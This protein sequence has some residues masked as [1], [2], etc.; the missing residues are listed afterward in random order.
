M[1]GQLVP[2]GLPVKRGQWVLRDLPVKPALPVLKVLPVSLAPL[3]PKD[4]LVL[5]D[6]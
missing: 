3:V 4:P 5:P 2:R 1:P 6:P